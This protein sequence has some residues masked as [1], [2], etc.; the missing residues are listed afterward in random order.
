[1][2][3]PVEPTPQSPTLAEFS[4][5]NALDKRLLGYQS[6]VRRKNWTIGF[7]IA[8]IL[9][10]V[11]SLV[12]TNAEDELIDRLLA[13]ERVSDSEIDDNDLLVLSVAMVGVV[14]YIATV[15]VFSM[16]IHRVSANLKP[17]DVSD[18]RFTP[19][20]AVGWWFIPIM[21]LWRPYQVVKEILKGSDPYYVGD[22]AGN[23]E[24]APVWRWLGWWWGIWI[25]SGMVGTAAFRGYWSAV[26]LEEIREA[27]QTGYLADATFIA[28]SVL[29]IFLVKVI[30]DRQEHKFRAAYAL[31]LSTAQQ[32]GQAGLQERSG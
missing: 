29:A 30:S 23:W 20:W 4:R 16:W 6:P 5:Q 25:I 21:W 28:V 1:V 17:L 14:L 31:N 9:L 10:A 27:N 13:G 3:V 11:I 24:Q 8:G 7:L 12:V 2:S 15:V 26:T 18:Q 32:L 22:R 19:A